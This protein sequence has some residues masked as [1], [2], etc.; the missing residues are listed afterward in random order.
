VDL[1]CGA[2]GLS[3]GLRQAGFSVLVGADN[4][5]WAVETHTANIGGLGY[6]GDL[7]DPADFI[8]HLDG[9]GVVK[10]DLV[11]GGVPC[12][13][14]S[15]A[16]RSRL[17]DLVRAG[18]RTHEDPRAQLWRSFMTVV[19]HLQP[20]AV[21]VE[22][23]PDLPTWDDGAVIIGFFESLTGLGYEVDA[24]ILES[25]AHGVPQ[26]R[27]RLL[28][29]GLRRAGCL[30]WPKPLD[31]ITT[32]RDAI[33]DLPPVPGG[34]RSDTLPYRPRRGQAP[35]AFQAR[36]R[37][38]LTESE[39]VVIHDHITRAVRTDDMQAFE[40][41]G[42]GQTYEDLPPH[43][44]RYR[45]DIFTDKYKR[46][47]WD[48]LSRTITAHIAKDGYWYIHPEQ[49]RTLSIREAARVQTFPDGF[50]FAGNPSHRYKQIGNA[51]PPMLGRAVGASLAAALR[52]RARTRS[53]SP[54]ADP[55]EILLAWHRQHARNYPWRARDLD[56]WHVL[57]AEMCLHRT[58]AD[59]VRPVFNALLRIA[60][61]PRDMVTNAERALE[62]MR[63]LGL[64]W[65]AENIVRV[66]EALVEL[67]D[68]DVPDDDLELQL[69][70]GVGDYVSHAV[71][72]F[73]FGHR[74]AL[75]DTN[76]MRVVGRLHG[77][78][79]NRRWQLRLD[80]HRLAGGPGPDAEFNYALL[81]F[82]ALVCRASNPRCS[83]CPLRD[84]CAMGS[85]ATP[86]A[87]LELTRFVA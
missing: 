4:D 56:P 9:W 12:Q 72:C 71:R 17:R 20:R 18:I 86:P 52:G 11:V 83:M 51:V 67:F 41:L 37:E 58:R 60:P 48:E 76:T 29:I 38:G 47:T 14:F 15:N 8:E 63:S 40:L 23:V 49:H 79:I 50:R 1:F 27:Q 25:F 46:L 10:V 42:E 80:L 3:L 66:A 70:P 55:R 44:Q 54:D 69:L 61:T 62:A 82:G 5:Q 57:M 85:G 16:G 36:M 35:T 6:T 22:N 43:L 34:Q 7:T 39:S 21:L 78:D 2:G 28:I 32:L 59:Q 53:I 77:R 68:G 24:R 81:D 13:P 75:L 64:R 33:G 19:E 87:Q 65:R 31:G 73:G 84:R 30:E 26:H 45:T 74:A